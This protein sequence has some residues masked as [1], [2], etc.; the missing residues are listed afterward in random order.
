MKETR[1]ISQGPGGY[2]AAPGQF[3][4]PAPRS[5]KTAA[6]ALL[7]NPKGRLYLASL[8]EEA[9]RLDIIEAYAPDAV[10][11]QEVRV[12]G[13]GAQAEG[14]VVLRDLGHRAAHRWAVHFRN[15]QLGGYHSGQYLG[16]YAEALKTFGEQAAKQLRWAAARSHFEPAD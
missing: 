1:Y 10:T 13:I 14:A 12:P 16:D 8:D 3:V 9:D 15:D 4:T 2:F 11:L 5:Y 7:A 6:H